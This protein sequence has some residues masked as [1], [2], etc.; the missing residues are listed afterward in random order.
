MARSIS[1]N[2]LRGHLGTEVVVGDLDQDARAVAHQGI[3]THGTAVVQV[4]QDLQTLL[5]DGVRL[6]ALD[7]GHEAHAA[8]VVL[9]GWV[10][11]PAFGEGLNFLAGRGP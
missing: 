4:L 8:G 11:Q 6:L 9:I 1:C 10:V 3:G 5:N 7:V 2:A